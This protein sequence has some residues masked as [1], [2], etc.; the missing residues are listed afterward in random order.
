[1]N[2]PGQSRV[3]DLGLGNV[4]DSRLAVGCFSGITANVSATLGIKGAIGTTMVNFYDGKYSDYNYFYATGEVTG[5]T[6]LQA[7]GNASAEFNFF[8]AE[9][10]G[11]R[12]ITPE[13]FA[14]I[15]D[16]YELSTGFST[17]IGGV[18]VSIGGFKSG[19]WKGYYLGASLGFGGEIVLNA[20]RAQ[21]LSILL[22]NVKPTATRS[23]IDRITNSFSGL[24]AVIQAV[25]QYLEK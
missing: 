7:G 14:G 5:S 6:G 20:S 25:H 15:T 12:P 16:S 2:I 21:S 9:M 24:P 1:M 23:Y 22:N 3:V 11:N 18:G 19:D 13:S 8:V 17:P 10:Q 4:D